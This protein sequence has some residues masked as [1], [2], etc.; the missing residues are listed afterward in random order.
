MEITSTVNVFCLL[1]ILVCMCTALV[2][3]YSTCAPKIQQESHEIHSIRS[4][5]VLS[6][7]I[8]NI[9]IIKVK[10]SYKCSLIF[11]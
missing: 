6:S 5:N 7:S 1:V 4:H 9:L 2:T 10:V 11:V 3:H 8:L